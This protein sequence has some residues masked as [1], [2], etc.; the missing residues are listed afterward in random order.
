MIAHFFA[1]ALIAFIALTTVYLLDGYWG[2]F[3]R[4]FAG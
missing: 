4:I 1:S 3:M 2:G